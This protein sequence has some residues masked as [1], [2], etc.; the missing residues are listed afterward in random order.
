MKRIQAMVSIVVLLAS[1][2]VAAEQM[3]KWVGLDGKINYTDTPPPA[4]VIRAETKILGNTGVATESLPYEVAQAV[5]GNPVTLYTTGS[6]TA[7]DSARSFLK[8]RGIPFSEKTVT[9]AEDINRVKQIGGSDTMPM[10]LVGRSKQAG[11]ESSAW[12]ALLSAAGYPQTSK[13]PQGYRNP[14]ATAAAPVP[15]KIIMDAA[16]NNPP[17]APANDKSVPD[18]RF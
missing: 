11:F 2:S 4:A 14:A 13:L 9:T 6:C 15:T 12:D 10:I 18:F 7:C 3:Y 17:V 8:Q 5:K 16:P 1:G